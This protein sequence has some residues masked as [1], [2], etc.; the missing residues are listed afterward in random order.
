MAPTHFL[1]RFG[2]LSVMLSLV[3]IACAEDDGRSPDGEGGKLATG[4]SGGPDGTGGA[5]G[6]DGGA[7]GGGDG[8]DGGVGGGGAGGV[9]EEWTYEP[10]VPQRCMPDDL[11]ASLERGRWDERFFPTGVGG[12]DGIAPAVHDFAVDTDD[13][14]LAVGRFD[15]LADREV[16]PLLRLEEE[17]W[18]QAWDVWPEALEGKSFSAIATTPE[19]DL[20]LATLILSAPENL[21]PS[22]L[23]TFDPT[24]GGWGR[25]AEIWLERDG[26]L[27][28]IGVFDGS[29]RSMHWWK[30]ELWIAG[31]FGSYEEEGPSY[32]AIWDGDTWR[33][34]EGG[35]PSDPV[36]VLFPEDDRIWVG[37]CFQELGG[38]PAISLAY[39][40]GSA[41][42]AQSLREPE[43][44]EAFFICN[45]RPMIFGIAR[46]E[47]DL[48][49]GGSLVT[50]GEEPG[51]FSGGL[52]RLGGD[53]WE[54]VG[55]GVASGFYAGMIA[56]LVAADDG[57]YATGCITHLGGGA[58][59]PESI[60]T[61][62]HARWSS[63]GWQPLV[64]AT[65]EASVASSWYQANVCGDEM[66]LVAIWEAEHQRA[67]SHDGSIYFAG[68]HPGA[69]GVPSQGLIAY[70][71]EDWLPQSPTGLGV[72]GVVD[73][74]QFGGPDCSLY[75]KG[76]ISHGGD[77][78]LSSFFA[79]FH[80]EGWED[81][82][83]PPP[84]SYRDFHRC[85]DFVVDGEGRIFLG[86]SSEPIF[87]EASGFQFTHMRLLRFDGSEWAVFGEDL[88]LRDIGTLVLDPLDRVWI[89][90]GSDRG[91]LARWDEA[92]ERIV[93]VEDAF[94]GG[95]ARHIAFR[96]RR[97]EGETFFP[98]VV[99]GFF[100]RVGAVDAN[101][102]ALWEAGEWKALGEGLTNPTSA[103]AY[104]SD[105]TIYAA[106]E[107]WGFPRRLTFG[108]WD[109][110]RWRELALREAGLEAPEGHLHTVRQILPV[111]DLVLLAGELRG[112][113]DF[114]HLYLYDG[115][116]FRAVGGGIAAMSLYTAALGADGIWAGG[117]VAK[118]AGNGEGIIQSMG[119]AHFDWS[120]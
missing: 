57:L 60:P 1:R 64:A 115:S 102:V 35:S 98:M 12:P 73:Q 18:Q 110:S 28:Q 69:A 48:Y 38:T 5:G 56:D 113:D 40:D 118:V 36:Y 81:P 111:G 49:V 89:S 72:S 53:G 44:N 100:E 26:V 114:G 27:E 8:G 107:D 41:W 117:W 58:L 20:A 4:G 67:F 3:L 15:A 79:R 95:G 120:D 46:Y 61:H 103:L 54:E 39:W 51:E 68:T 109:G 32:L 6:G 62:G 31:V 108:A 52:A 47:G 106:T 13:R 96:D 112:Q 2:V 43:E 101:F 7:G 24:P 59:D 50:S 65:R 71:G 91:W 17:G 75:A 94:H 104:A 84:E 82:V 37:G 119:I 87:D 29:I 42:T 10:P 116:T 83:P 76:L 105:G 88:N 63:E 80:G 92:E 14:L 16:Q 30:G 86:C 74:L 66:S 90:G 70:D 21:L 99:G 25:V 33:G 11:Q 78:S 77:V 34:A 9:D 85:G 45:E 22:P 19:G 23:S 93:V 97:R 55:G